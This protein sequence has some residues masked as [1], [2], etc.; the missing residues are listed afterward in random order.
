M[1][2]GIVMI[3]FFLNLSVY[4]IKKEVPK[5]YVNISLVFGLLSS[6]G[7]I[8]TG[9][10]PGDGSEDLHNIVASFFFLGGLA[11]CI[12]Y[13]ISEL[14]GK[15]ISKF[16][17]LSGFVVACFFVV[18]LFFSTINFYNPELALELSHF[19]EWILFTLLM[20]WIFEHEISMKR[21]NKLT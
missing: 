6:L 9:F 19:S 1:V 2:T 8:L 17:A 3:F 7:N 12:L 10:F 11:Y 14:K 4:L 15:G 5:M 20:F 16:Q 21:Y 18:F 13:G